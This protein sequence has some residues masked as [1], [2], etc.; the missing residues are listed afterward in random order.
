MR[1][2]PLSPFQIAALEGAKRAGGKLQRRR[3]GWAPIA[4]GIEKH[5]FHVVFSLEERGLFE[6]TPDGREVHLTLAG[7]A[8]LQ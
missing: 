2:R 3:D 5:L 7:E 4:H 1:D 8:L 6:R